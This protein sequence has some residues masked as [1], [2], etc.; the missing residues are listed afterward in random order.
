VEFEIAHQTLFEIMN[1]PASLEL[2][3]KVVDGFLQALTIEW[4][5]EVVICAG[6]FGDACVLRLSLC[7]SLH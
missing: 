4:L 5:R 1:S 3:R 2:F 7:G 6:P